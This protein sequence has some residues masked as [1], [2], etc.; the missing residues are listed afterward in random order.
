MEY[1]TPWH[2]VLQC[3]VVH[4]RCQHGHD[5]PACLSMISVAPVPYL[6]IKSPSRP[7]PN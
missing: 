6:K 3:T 2:S 1:G 5:L 7:I 4:E